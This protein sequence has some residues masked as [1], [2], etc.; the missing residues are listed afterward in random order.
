MKK[1][2]LLQVLIVLVIIIKL[3][4]DISGQVL[5]GN[6]KA[7]VSKSSLVLLPPENLQGPEITF[8]WE[9]VDLLWDAPGLSDWLQWDN[10]INGDDGVGVSGGGTFYVASHWYPDD[11]SSYGGFYLNKIKYYHYENA[12]TASFV[13]KVWQGENAGTLLLSQDVDES[14]PGQWNEIVL[15]TPVQIDTSQE[16]WFGYEVTHP[17]QENPA[18]VDIGPAIQYKGDM[19]SLD[20]TTWVSMSVEYDLNF[21]WNLAARVSPGI[22][23]DSIDFPLIKKINGLG[24]PDS[25]QLVQKEPGESF[26]G[27]KDTL[28]LSYYKV[29][30]DGQFYDSTTETSYYDWDMPNITTEYTYFVTAVY[31][32]QYE[33]GPSNS[34]IVNV[35]ICSTNEFNTKMLI[36]YPNPATNFV[37]IE[38][39]SRINE[40]KVYNYAGQIVDEIATNEFTFKLNTTQYKPGIYF[41]RIETDDGTISK[42]LIIK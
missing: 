4:P 24:F 7:E 22:G 35:I 11:L 6:K 8:G 5:I 20:S 26:S 15:N 19:I 12:P 13:I 29:Y 2:S 30:R 40:I 3:T 34:I 23:N 39:D 31:N 16:L 21:N 1:C 36:V 38:S 14:I 33:S 37:N 32:G 42:R 28:I 17:D 18:G 9:G 10:G 41:I 27:D 25:G